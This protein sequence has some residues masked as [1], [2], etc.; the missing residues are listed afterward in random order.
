MM[1]PAD[2]AVKT[3]KTT[4]RLAT[5]QLGYIESFDAVIDKKY[6]YCAWKE[7]APDGKWKIKIK[8]NITVTTVLDPGNASIKRG[9]DKAAG[10]DETSFLWGF[11][12]KPKAGDTR[13]VQNRILLDKKGK[14]TGVEVHLVTR[15]ADGSPRDAEVMAFPWPAPKA[16]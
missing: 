11:E 14:P 12:M 4:D 13:L 6:A 2:Q 8:G 15:K 7:T 16:E 5:E 1:D 9:L 10:H 3:P